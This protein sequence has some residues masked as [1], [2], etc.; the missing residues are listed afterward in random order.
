[1]PPA[2]RKSTYKG[3]SKMKKLTSIFLILSLLIGACVFV[4]P[5]SAS[6]SVLIDYG[7]KWHYVAYE[8]DP[9]VGL[10]HGEP[11][12]WLEG[13]DSED[14]QELLGLSVR[15]RAVPPEEFTDA[16]TLEL[17]K[18]IS[19]SAAALFFSSSVARQTPEFAE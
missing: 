19:S 15:L 12:G 9:E 1:M 11:E 3:Y 4:L 16:F 17:R 10:V 14:W 18:S 2:C 13:T 5:A 6:D 8:E 7:S